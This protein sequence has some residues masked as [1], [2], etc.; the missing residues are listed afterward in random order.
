L[1]ICDLAHLSTQAGLDGARFQVRFLVLGQGKSGTSAVSRAIELSAG[2]EHRAFF[3]PRGLESV[4]AE[5]S[6]DVV[7]KMLIEHWS[8]SDVAHLDWFDRCVF[9]ARDP[10]DVVVSRLLY[11][12][13]AMEFIYNPQKLRLFL[14]SLRTK[15]RAPGEHSVRAFFDLVAKLEGSG[16]ALKRSAKIHRKAAGLWHTASVRDSMHLLKYEDFVEGRV[17]A[18]SDYLGLEI[19]QDVNVHGKW[20]RV[21]RTRSNGDWKHWF[22][23]ADDEFAREAFAD[24]LGTFGYDDW[25]K[26]SEQIIDPEYSS[27][28]VRRIV[29]EAHRR[30][31]SALRKTVGSVFHPDHESPESPSSARRMPRPWSKSRAG[32]N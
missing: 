31:F 27:E 16:D 25:E 21:E 6:S 7:V 29:Q 10:R 8:S 30:R 26:P 2:P 11:Q 32:E 3:E 12:V 1:W 4:T 15:E 22:T 19:N 28:Y 5:G 24:Y 13:F 18:L 23:P 14:A 9:L 17:R 20:K